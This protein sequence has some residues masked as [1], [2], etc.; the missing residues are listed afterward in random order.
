MD[1]R[2]ETH[3]TNGSGPHAK[4]FVLSAI[5]AVLG[6]TAEPIYFAAAAQTQGRLSMGP[7]VSCLPVVD[8][9]SQ[10]AAGRWKPG[11]AAG[12]RRVVE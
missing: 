12:R 8:R 1:G 9:M 11:Q 10:P 2:H 7:F 6:A 4:A 3:A 5:C